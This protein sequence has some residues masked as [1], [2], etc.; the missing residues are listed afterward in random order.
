MPLR[1][2]ICIYLFIAN[3]KLFSQVSILQKIEVDTFVQPNKAYVS[4]IRTWIDL[5]KKKDLGSIFFSMNEIRIGVFLKKLGLNDSIVFK[6]FWNALQINKEQSCKC[7]STIK[8]TSV[9]VDIQTNNDWKKILRYCDFKFKTFAFDTIYRNDLMRD[10]ENL[11][12]NDQLYREEIGLLSFI[13]GFLS[14]DFKHIVDRQR[15][16]D[17]IN[18]IHVETLIKTRGY[19]NIKSVGEDLV[20]AP[21][22]VIIHSESLKIK[23]QYLPIIIDAYKKS[24]LTFESVQILVDKVYVQKFKKQVFGTQFGFEDENGNTTKYPIID[25]TERKKIIDSIK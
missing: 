5:K 18:M 10:L 6:Y 8:N 19:P 14:N 12:K 20:G 3:C 13:F 21:S 22:L 23:E 9:F 2:E 15:V 1:Y 24:N 25:E 11:Y 16:L 7:F 4:K 17:S